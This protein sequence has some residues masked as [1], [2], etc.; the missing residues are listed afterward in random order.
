MLLSLLVYC[1]FSSPESRNTA[2][3][4]QIL[5]GLDIQFIVFF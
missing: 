1:P 5:N 4:Q 3:T 2:V